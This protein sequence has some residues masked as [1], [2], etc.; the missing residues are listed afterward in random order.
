[1]RWD[2]CFDLSTPARR[3]RCLKLMPSRSSVDGPQ[4]IGH[5]QQ[6]I[7]SW[8]RTQI[9]RKQQDYWPWS[10]GIGS[11]W[12]V[13]KLY[14]CWKI[15]ILYTSAGS[16]SALAIT[17]SVLVLRREKNKKTFAQSANHNILDRNTITT[18]P[19]GA[20]SMM[21]SSLCAIESVPR[22]NPLHC[23]RRRSLFDSQNTQIEPQQLIY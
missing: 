14:I 5:V 23:S 12:R 21:I 1:M 4:Q 19:T 16:T 9:K 18:N 6:T 17:V 7:E 11:F 2:C 22:M 20:Y 10:G 8:Y 13:R 15:V 3:E